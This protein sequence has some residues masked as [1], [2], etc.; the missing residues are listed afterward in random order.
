M[1]NCLKSIERNWSETIS[2]QGVKTTY[3]FNIW[4]DLWL[5]ITSIMI[6][7]KLPI[8][9]FC[10]LISFVTGE[11]CWNSFENI[12]ET[13]Q[14]PGRLDKDQRWLS[15]QFMVSKMECLDIC[16][17]TTRC[18]SFYLK[19]RIKN[20]ICIIL[21]KTPWE[22]DKLVRQNTGWMNFNVSSQKLQEVGS[23]KYQTLHY[24]T[25]IFG[26]F[27]A[28]YLIGNFFDRNFSSNRR[29]WDGS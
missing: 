4:T 20:W 27:R 15:K 11:S 19:Q 9:F 17:R 6:R 10:F 18:A 24:Q 5:E 28:C 29:H 12:L 16:L 22:S 25:S 2:F 26:G 21:Y 23:Q 8:I 13:R 1:I 7:E 14:I 3:D